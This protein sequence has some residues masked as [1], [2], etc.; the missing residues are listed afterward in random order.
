MPAAAGRMPACVIK[1]KIKVERSLASNSGSAE[2]SVSVWDSAVR[3]EQR[4][5]ASAMV[6][7]DPDSGVDVHWS[8]APA[9]ELKG[10]AITGVRPT[11]ARL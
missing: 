3:A 10:G 6:R 11:D 4:E 5:V 9:G 7:L 1:T 2:A 8:G